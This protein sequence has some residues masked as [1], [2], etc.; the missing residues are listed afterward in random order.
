MSLFS[1]RSLPFLALAAVA[2]TAPAAAQTA[3][4]TL[5]GNLGGLAKLSLSSTTL[6]FP[7]SNPDTV[8]QIPAAGGAIVITAKARATA[9]ATVTLTVLATDDLRSGL[10]T[11]PIT[12]LTWTAS[13]AGFVNG[14]MSRQVPQVVGTWAGSGVQT[15]TQMFRF[16]NSWAYATGTYSVSLVYTLVAP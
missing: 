10:D 1:R 12:A 6:S 7:D 11:I 3:T 14:T 2:F 16:Q 9:G 5:S 4:A 15:G 8:P 13:G